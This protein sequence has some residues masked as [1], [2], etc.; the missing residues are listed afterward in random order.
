M[1]LWF[2]E[3]QGV[4]RGSARHQTSV[5]PIDAVWSTTVPLLHWHRL[6]L[7]ER[8]AGIILWLSFALLL[9]S[10]INV[11]RNGAPPALLRR[12]ILTR[13]A[14][15]HIDWSTV[16]CSD[17]DGHQCLSTPINDICSLW[18]A[19]AEKWLSLIGCLKQERRPERF[20]LRLQVLDRICR[21]IQHQWGNRRKWLS[22]AQAV[23]KEPVS[24]TPSP[25]ALAF[26]F[27]LYASS[28]QRSFVLKGCFPWMTELLLLP[29][30]YRP[31]TKHRPAGTISHSNACPS[32]ENLSLGY[33]WCF[34]GFG[35]SWLPTT[36]LSRD[37]GGHLW[38]LWWDDL[39]CR[40]PATKKV[41]PTCL[42]HSSFE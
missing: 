25:V 20:N 5:H 16:A 31:S 3:L 23:S 10:S 13:F 1:V 30:M 24:N 42:S 29:E 9:T 36:V 15:R 38:T 22:S 7:S 8:V 12:L 11:E 18:M 35:T 40:E 39:W 21:L 41:W 28:V 2:Y 27:F 26:C 37:P 33:R 17:S 34:C 19:D 6:P 32:W 4:L 14:T